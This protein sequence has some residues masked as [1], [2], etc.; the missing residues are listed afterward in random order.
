MRTR[1]PR[2]AIQSA[3]LMPYKSWMRAAIVGAAVGGVSDLNHPAFG[4]LNSLRRVLFD[5]RLLLARQP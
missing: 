4:Q 2:L 1:T 3:S 5:P